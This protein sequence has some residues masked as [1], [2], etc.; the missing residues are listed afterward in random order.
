M[1]EAAAVSVV[2]AARDAQA[3]LGDTLAALGAQR[4]APPHEVIVVDNGS[5]DGTAALAEAHPLRPRVLRRER[6]A[7]PGAARNDGA[8][9]AKAPLLAFTDADC[10]PAPDW[11]RRGVAVAA[12]ADVVQGAIQPAP[13]VTVGPFDRT[14]RVGAESGLYETANLFIKREWFDRAGGFEDVIEAGRP[15]G[16]DAVLVWRARRLGARTAFAADA[17]VHHAVLPGGPAGYL[18]ERS[19]EGLFAALLRHVPELREGFLYHRWFLNRRS[20]AFDLG[21]AGLAAAAMRRSAWPLV[22]F[23]P[24]VSLVRTESRHRGGGRSVTA[25]VA[26]GDALSFLSRVRGS[27]RERTPV[28]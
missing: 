7:G 23:A 26:Y 18:S 16:E 13:E 25:I 10:A 21:V 20:A 22:A 28:L 8:R 24:W 27:I 11:L 1:S 2:I 4:D 3:S 15:F 9:A 17:L 14:L 19:R 5:R 12:G 6:G